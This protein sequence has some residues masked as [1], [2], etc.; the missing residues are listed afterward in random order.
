MSPDYS[1]PFVPY[2]PV[3]LPRGGCG[4]W[5]H[6]PAP[7]RPSH[8]H[9]RQVSQGHRLP[10]SYQWEAMK[11][12]QHEDHVNEQ[13]TD[14]LVHEGLEPGLRPEHDNIHRVINRLLFYWPV[15]CSFLLLL[16]RAIL[17]DPVGADYE[18][19]IHDAHRRYQYWLDATSTFNW[20][21]DYNGV[22]TTASSTHSYD[23]RP[24]ADIHLDEAFEP[25]KL[26]QKDP[27]QFSQR[28]VL[29]SRDLTSQNSQTEEEFDEGPFFK[30]IFKLLANMPSQP[31]Q[32]NLHLTSIISQL[33][34]L[35]HP[36]LH[37]YLLNPM[38]PTAKKTPTLFKTLQEVARR[39]TM[40]IPRL[41][42]FKKIIENTRL[43]LM[44]EDPSYDEK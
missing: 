21:A 2:V 28:L 35:P 41:R 44:S 8:R 15:G 40:E 43:W 10:G 42:N 18:H 34:L 25:L 12:L 23:S 13:I 32:V 14:I 1:E 3:E 7:R 27:K 36:N 19:Y 22:D 38:L 4:V 11:Q 9:S 6:G 16:P 31:Y 26:E 30:M 29:R 39:L 17:S 37:E 5:A 24:E 20:P 33:A